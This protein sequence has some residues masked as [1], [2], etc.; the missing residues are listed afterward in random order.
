LTGAA[1]VSA[2]G[3]VIVVA[4]VIDGA[5]ATVS[6]AA[7]ICRE[8]RRVAIDSSFHHIRQREFIV[9]PK[10]ALKVSAKAKA[11]TLVRALVTN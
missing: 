2:D 5:A 9:S 3:G 6:L 11:R 4:G 10:F 8:L 7:C 1:G